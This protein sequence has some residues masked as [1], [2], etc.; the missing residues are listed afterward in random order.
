MNFSFNELSA[1]IN[2]AILELGFKEPTDIQQTAIPLLLSKDMDFVGQ[3]QT[4]TGKTA[5]FGL[6]LL[7]KLDLEAKGIQA[8]ILSPTRELANQ[9]NDEIMKFGQYLDLRTATIFGGV[10]YDRQIANVRKAQIVIATPG[11]A[12]DLLE[13][14]NLDLRN[15]KHFVIDEADEML[16][17]GF[18]EDVETLMDSVSK[19]AKTWMFSATMPRPI[20]DLIEG[21]LDNPEMIRVKNKTL[22]S[23][24]IEQT[25][26]RIQ[27]RDFIKV[28]KVILQSEPEFFGIVFC[29]TREETR[30]LHERLL[31]LDRK[32]AALHGDL[33]QTQRDIAIGQFRNRKVDILVCTDVAARGLDISEV[34][35]VINMGLPRKHESYVHRV[36]RTGR[37]GQKGVAI[38]FVSP[39]DMHN[40]RAIERLTRQKMKPFEL[41]NIKD[42]KKQKVLDAL[43]S[44]NGIKSAI[45][46]KGEEFLLDESF[47]DFWDYFDGMSR[48]DLMKI[49]FSYNF[50]KDLRA[51][52]ESMASLKLSISKSKSDKGSER[53]SE[54]R[55]DR[56]SGRRGDRRDD[57]GGNRG[58]RSDRRDDRRAEGRD[59]RRSDNRGNRRFKSSDEKRSSRGGG[60]GRRRNSR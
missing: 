27:R 58:R 54:R 47:Q 3:A 41:P 52:D 18:I 14:G 45:I 56:R 24:N 6:P 11:R 37:A 50:K 17:M 21:K 38:S 34:T 28:L 44:M 55:S 20:V 43:E 49:F 59:D 8:F 1:P 5:A 29:E 57:R 15:C 35:H 12:L 40:L 25:Y 23:E 26:V 33:N 46:E 53:R 19:D 16:K 32:V 22:S 2:Q 51:M 60:Q 10:G 7:E 13:R 39:S 4:G 42:V 31:E 48:T 30:Q 36:G 9:I